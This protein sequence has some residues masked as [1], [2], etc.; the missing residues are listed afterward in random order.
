MPRTFHT[1]DVFTRTR[2]AG[3]PLAVVLDADGLDAPSMQAIAREFNLSETVFVLPP[4]NAVNTARLRIFTPAAELPFAGHPTIGAA[5]L[6]ADLRADDLL[7]RG[8][9]GVALEEEVG[10]I[11]CSVWRSRDGCLQ[12]SFV[13]PRLPWK[14]GAAPSVG[15]LAAALS[16]AEDDIGFDRHV[17]SVWSAGTAFILAPIASRAAVARARPAL[18]RWSELGPPEQRKVFLYSKETS[19]D[20]HHVHARMFA[21]GVGV[22][23]DPATG[24]AVAALAGAAA[25]AER[26]ED[27]DHAIYV[28]QGEEMGRPSLICLEMRIE[29]GALR[30]AAISG[31]VI[32]IADGSLRV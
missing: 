17:P 1:L 6:I 3:N 28:E 30:R 18:D 21:P 14:A 19:Q 12:A 31:S 4:R 8:E 16:L 32:R 22:S 9:L 20:G 23:E 29:D 13:L 24:S 7:T 11:S 10:E 5:A 27:G 15:A 26:P 2:L 25:E